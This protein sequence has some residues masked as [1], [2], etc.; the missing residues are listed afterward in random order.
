LFGF[1]ALR[2]NT[3]DNEIGTAVSPNKQFIAYYTSVY[4]KRGG[5]AEGMKISVLD[6]NGNTVWNTERLL[7]H[8][9]GLIQLL[10]MKVSDSGYVYVMAKIKSKD[11]E[12]IKKKVLS[13]KDSGNEYKELAMPRELT[14]LEGGE[15]N[16]LENG[17]FEIYGYNKPKGG[18]RRG[19]EVLVYDPYSKSV[20]SRVGGTITS[21]LKVTAITEGAQKNLD[22]QTKRNPER[23]K[24]GLMARQ[25]IK[26]EDGSSFLIGEHYN[27]IKT[28]MVDAKGETSTR[29]S[30]YYGDIVV[31][32]IA[33]NGDL[34]WEAQIPKAQHSN[35]VSYFS[36]V[37]TTC[38]GEVN[39]V[40]N[41]R[42]EN[43][44]PDRKSKKLALYKGPIDPAQIHLFNIDAQ[45]KVSDYSI[46]R[47]GDASTRFK[48][49]NAIAV[50]G[51]G[52][53]I[54]EESEGKY[55]GR[56]VFQEI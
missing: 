55:H 37:A 20:V 27:I 29:L 14:S 3:E 40:F 46:P 48:L 31:L 5:E 39:I 32:K 19:Y 44:I 47:E 33:E 13:F 42:P 43:C 35:L 26:Q 51:C 38:N 18:E 25:L 2:F 49:R 54:M 12:S 30:Y 24:T 50:P 1:A 36:F 9:S 11:S 15:W 52:V 45:G 53:F 56:F 22:K 17:F 7:K 10:D 4:P 41:D 8:N 28:V 6:A 23:F 34:V 16:L 21:N